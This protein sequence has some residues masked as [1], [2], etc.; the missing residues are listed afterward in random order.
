[1]TKKRLL[2]PLLLFLT[3]GVFAQHPLWMRYPTI[4]PDGSEVAFSYQ[5]DIY[6]VSTKGGTAIRLTTDDSFE[7]QPIWSPDGR[8]IA[9]V[10]DRVGG[11]K[12]IFL[13][14]SDG[15][16]AKRLTT[17]SGTETPQ[18]FTKDGKYVI[19]SAQIQDPA[20]SA[21]FPT[22][23]LSEVYQ[24][25][26]ENRQIQQLFA[27][28]ATQI[29]FHPTQRKMIYQ[30]QKSFENTWRKHHTSSATRD[31]LEYDFQT[32]T[33]TQLISWKGEDTNPVYAPDGNGFYF[34]SER[35]GTYNIYFATRENPQKVRQI[36]SFKQNPIR[37]L[38][39]ADNGTLC[40]GYDGEIYTLDTQSNK[41][42]KLTINIRN[43]I[44]T[45]K[46]HKIVQT[47]GATSVSVSADGKQIA[48][49]LRGEVFV[50]AT[51]YTTTKQITTTTAE[52]SSVN[53]SS[54]NRTIAYSSYRDGYW[55]IYTAKITR[56]EEANFPNATLITEKALITNDK[57]EKQHPKFSPDGK[58]VAFVQDRTQLVVYDT[59]TNQKTIITDGKYQTERDGHITYEWS[60]DGKWF[61][62]EYVSNGHAPYSDIGIVST[63]GGKIVNITQSG[64]FDRN[65][66]WVMDGNAIL[67]NSDQYGMRNHASW[68]SMSDAMLVF[69]NKKTYN[70]YQ[71]D[72]ETY[73]IYQAEEKKKKEEKETKN[74]KKETKKTDK[75]DKQKTI[76]IEWENIE[77]RIVRL[78][79][80]ASLM[81]D[82]Y[83]TKDGE[84]LYYFAAFEGG[85]DMWVTHLRKKETKL[86]KKINASW[87]SIVP[88]K[89]EKNLFLLG[90]NSMQKMTIGGEKFSNIGYRATLKINDYKEREA[91][92]NYVCREEQERFYQKNMHGV[93]WT[94]LTNHYRKFLPHISNGYDF[95]EMLSELLGELN[96]SHTGSGYRPAQHNDKTA[97]LG[98]FVTQNKKQIFVDEIIANSPFDNF[99]SKLQKGDILEK[100]DGQTIQ[101]LTEYYAQLNDKTGK[102]TLISIYRPTTNER[103]SEVTKPISKGA[104]NE[105]LYKRWVEQRA[106]EVKRL[107]N[108]RLGYVHIRSMGDASFRKIYADALGKYYQKEAIV[109]DIR[110]NGGGRLHE[111]VEVFFSGRQ[112]LTQEIRGKDYCEMPS[113]RWNK[114]SIMLMTEADYSNAHGT[115]WVYKYMQI[116]KLVGMPVAGTMTS[117][118]WVTLQD[119]NLYFGIPVIGYRTAEG[120]YLENDQLEPDVKVPLDLSRAVEGNDSQLEVAVQ[121]LL[122][123]LDKK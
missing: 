34:L 63:E 81:G 68:G 90:S 23:I 30:D 65:P 33:T 5:G 107:S 14:S 88:D 1:M 24:V 16:R 94:K 19:F 48:F 100:I 52:E 92:Y 55:N 47:N 36:T 75:V 44:D 17:H 22:S 38:T 37:F 113:R 79:P 20:Q 2:T 42:Q 41:S 91:M 93:N 86:L 62:I 66:R 21:L 95:S 99:K 120:T 108:G 115:P 25:S 43:D 69:M 84:K 7:S 9:F 101:N 78:T 106:D 103:W 123:Q 110:Y 45:S 10:S 83:V 56:E 76:N 31:I 46:Q 104:L 82:A 119:P 117:V 60:P 13:M 105:L 6:K 80:N 77:K 40:F 15:G 11:S 29:N 53:F 67:Y 111:D 51:D 54:D 89:E 27:Y 74:D 98:L 71:M 114:P 96:V 26:V 57:H 73:E 39:I 85:Y 112:Y 109:I 118:N 87:Y 64:Y 49:T 121:T 116:G 8:F 35:D 72:K 4:S 61:V 18:T 58:K 32:Q 59:E 122:K 70:I 12:D 102:N 28:P 97:E 3:V 50:T